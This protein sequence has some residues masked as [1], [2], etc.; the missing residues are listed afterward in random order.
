MPKLCTVDVFY[1][2][3]A[4]GNQ[5]HIAYRPAPAW[6][7]TPSQ[8]Q[9]VPNLILM[10]GRSGAFQAQFL[11]YGRPVRRCGSGNLAV[12]AY[13]NEKL[14]TK[15]INECLLTPAGEIQL[16]FDHESAYYFDRPLTQRPLRSLRFWRRLIS[17]PVINGCYCGGRNDY[18]LLELA[19]PLT[20]LRLNSG[21]LCQFSQ[22]ALIVIYRLRSGTVQ[23]RY[24]APQYGEAEDAATGSASVQAAAYLRTQYP[25]RYAHQSIE[26]K[27]CSPAGGCLYL[28]NYQQYVLIR[29]QTAMRD[30][31]A[32]CSSFDYTEE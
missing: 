14:K 30:N 6:S 17:R 31:K 12:A 26:I 1:G 28:K 24:F 20:Q 2:P 11:N 4:L 8:Y 7:E 18:V 3:Q 23:L 16:G 13:I 22:R 32:I 9:T 5:H 15:P 29:G 21:A 19:Q 27:Q 10:S 25:K